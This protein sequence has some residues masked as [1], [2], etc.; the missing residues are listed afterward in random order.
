MKMGCINKRL[1]V[2]DSNDGAQPEKKVT[3][4]PHK[5]LDLC[6]TTLLEKKL[7]SFDKTHQLDRLI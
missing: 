3:H 2:F 7:G 4:P 5:N 6:Q 1:I